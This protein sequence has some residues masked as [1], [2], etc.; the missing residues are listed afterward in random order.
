VC[1]HVAY[2]GPPTDLATLLLEPP[3]SLVDQARAA[4]FQSSGA[5]NPDGFGAGWYEPGAEGRQASRYRSARPV[6]EDDAF[7]ALAAST[8][9]RAA[10]AAVRLASPGAPIEV[11]GNAPFV[12]GP[13]LFSLNGVV[14]GHFEGVG[15]ELR[16]TLSPARAAGIEGVA[17]SE[18]LFALALDHLD[19][20]ASPGEALAAVIAA[21]TARTTGRLNLLLTDGTRVAATAWENSLFTRTVA[22]PGPGPATWV[23][24][25]PLD[26]DPGWVRVPDRTLVEVAAPGSG[27]ASPLDGSPLDGVPLDGVPLGSA[28]QLTGES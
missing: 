3:H 6:W 28:P 10:L 8:T 15:A 5:E 26:A 9:T 27:T 16:A 24:S 11:S 20:G 7:P 14:H 17:D 22:G 21:V 4:R 23:A 18:V 2:L 19:A 13:W 25:E 1:R 12:A